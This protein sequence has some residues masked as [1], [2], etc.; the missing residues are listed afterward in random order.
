MGF[1]NIPMR[2]RFIQLTTYRRSSAE[3][4]TPV[5]F[6]RSRR[7]VYIVTHATAGKL[8]R[9]SANPRVS[10]APCRS[11]G[12]RTGP[13]CAGTARVLPDDER[14]RAAKAISRRYFLVPRALVELV[15]RRRGRGQP[16]VYIEVVPAQ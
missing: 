1:A 11:Q 6:A 15:M 9:I 12:K 7:G 3:V 16:A 8:K 5:W 2:A 10:L 14:Q 4:S 13:E